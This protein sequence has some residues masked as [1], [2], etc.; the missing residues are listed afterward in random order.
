VNSDHSDKIVKLFTLLDRS[1][2]AVTDVHRRNTQLGA[3]IEDK[4][5]EIANMRLELGRYEGD[6]AGLHERLAQI[7]K[8]IT[9]KQAEIDHLRYLLGRWPA[10][11]MLKTMRGVSRVKNGK[12][13]STPMP[14]VE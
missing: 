11:L 2:A 3:L 7:D 14:S 12:P 6:M 4:D 9:A 10:R 5:R 13:K 1:D 8:L